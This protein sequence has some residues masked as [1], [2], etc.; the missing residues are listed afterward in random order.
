M[1]GAKLVLP[2]PHLDGKNIAELINAENVTFSAGVPTVWLGLLQYLDKSHGTIDCMKRIFSGGSA[3][4]LSMLEAFDSYGVEM[5]QGW[6]MTETTAGLTSNLK[7][8]F[9]DRSEDEKYK[10]RAMQGFPLFGI[11]M[12][13]V[14]DGG[15]ALPHDGETMG[16]VQIRGLWTTKAYYKEEKEALSVDGWLPTGDVALINSGRLYAYS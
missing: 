2:G 1:V 6:G 7:P 10:I 16:E 4:P 12:R 9:N 3:V 14:D 15:A 11:D 13:I 8:C 5:L